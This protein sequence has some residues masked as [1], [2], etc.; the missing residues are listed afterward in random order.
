MQN[1]QKK[2]LFNS[3]QRRLPGESIKGMDP[4]Q[5]QNNPFTIKQHFYHFP[6]QINLKIKPTI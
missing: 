1:D 3:L 2:E 6:I 5:F 4:A